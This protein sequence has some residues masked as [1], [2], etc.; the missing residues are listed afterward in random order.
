MFLNNMID[1]KNFIKFLKKND[2]NF[3]CG[4]P[5]SILK[6]F[7]FEIEKE[8]NNYITSNEG[9]A[10]SLGAGYHLATGKMP[11]IYMQNSG[12]G[13]S[14]NPLTSLNHKKVFS[15]PSLM[16]IGWRGSPNSKDEP[17]HKIKGSI[18]RELLDLMG[19]K[20]YILKT[21]QKRIF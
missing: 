1:P 18:T 11:C 3:F 16:L 8:K 15:L 21:I 9:T 17:Q 10:V 5:D 19:V 4:V 7:S 2:I 6:S 13:N 12:L 14:V 20:Y